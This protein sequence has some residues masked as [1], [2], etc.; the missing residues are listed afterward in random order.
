MIFLIGVHVVCGTALLTRLFL[1]FRLQESLLL[2]VEQTFP[3]SENT[4]STITAMKS[5]HMNWQTYWN[6]LQL[7]VER[8][9]SC[10][11]DIVFYEDESVCLKLDLYKPV[12]SLNNAPVLLQIHGGGWSM[13]S[14]HHGIPLMV[15][16]AAQGWLCVSISYRLSP[17][18]AF[19][20]HLIDC[21]RAIRWIHEKGPEYGADPSSIFVVGESA[22]AHLAALSAL[23]PNRDEYQPGFEAVNTSLQGCVAFYGVY[24]FI[25]PFAKKTAYP[26]LAQH[27]EQIVMQCSMSENRILFE[28]ASPVYCLEQ[29][30]VPFLLIHGAN[31]SMVPIEESLRFYH[32][33]RKK[34]ASFTTF[35][36][37]PL[38]QHGFDTLPSPVTQAVIP[39]IRQYLLQLRAT[40]QVHNNLS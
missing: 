12:S 39:A 13:G 11:L 38:T 18:V 30:V 19:P 32:H 7:L 35:L 17:E 26:A 33:L 6:P 4:G 34:Q 25:A 15:E 37:L 1:L 28:K 27:L 23:T 2:Q 21:K 40:I 20:E 14:R 22:G 29:G 24:D 10:L 16:M 8:Q 31:D 5:A 36:R 9:V 3:V